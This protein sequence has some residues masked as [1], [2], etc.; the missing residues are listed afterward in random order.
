MSH[1]N[2]ANPFPN[3]PDRRAIWDILMRRDFEAFVMRD[4][5]MVEQDFLAEEF[6][7]LDAAR[8]ANP[9]HWSLRYATL[10]AYREEWLRQA[11]AFGDIELAGEEKLDFFYRAVTLRDIEIAGDHAVAHKK[12]DGVA[13]TTQGDPVAIKWQTL[14]QMRKV[15]GDWKIAGF[16]GYLPHAMSTPDGGEQPTIQ[17]PATMRQH[18]K[19]GPYSP[20]LRIAPG[21]TVAISGQG[22]LDDAGN[23]IGATIE[24]QTVLTLENC[25]RQLEA[26]G[27]SLRD[28][29]KVM[30]YL[31]DMDEWARFNEIYRQYFAPPYPVRTAIG[32][33]LWGGIK[34]EL[35]MVA[36]LPG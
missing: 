35:D 28:V 25:R 8:R 34:V 32:C 14:Y 22:P 26:A 27:A 18:A 21:P 33:R 4:W 24:E 2:A 1:A 7:G 11:A 10:D 6:R 31:S 20:A 17:P 16:I 29:Y 5:S 3:D 13:R 12:F 9:D 30:V 15:G 23:I 36:R 19:A